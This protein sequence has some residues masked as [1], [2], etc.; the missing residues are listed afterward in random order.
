MNRKEFGT[1]FIGIAI[2]VTLTVAIVVWAGVFANSQYSNGG[3]NLL[4][5]IGTV[6]LI[7]ALAV[8]AWSRWHKTCA[9]PYCLRSGEH[10]VAGTLQKVCS[11]HHTAKHHELVYELHHAAHVASGRLDFGESHSHELPKAD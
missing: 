10:P 7:A 2:A 6:P 1:V 4:G 11:H 9:V 5:I 3:S 8:A